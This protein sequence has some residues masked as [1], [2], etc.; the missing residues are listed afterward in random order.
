MTAVRRIARL[1]ENVQEVAPRQPHPPARERLGVLGQFV[2][3]R[4]GRDPIAAVHLNPVSSGRKTRRL[5]E[6]VVGHLDR[7]QNLFSTGPPQGRI[8]RGDMHDAVVGEPLKARTRSDET[9][10]TRSGN[11][12]LIA[13]GEFAGD[14]AGPCS[15]GTRG[16]CPGRQN[17]R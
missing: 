5:E 9:G 7:C 3:S 6:A 1:D 10:K 15:T 12:S 2:R 16:E 8:A 14:R 11:E 17:T 13:Q 4:P